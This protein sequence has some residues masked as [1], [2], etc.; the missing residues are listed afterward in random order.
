V[1]AGRSG[2]LGVRPGRASAA[3][4]A[5]GL[6]ALLAAAAAAWWWTSGATERFYT[7]GSGLRAGP[8]DAP[9]RDVLWRTPEALDGLNSNAQE[10]A[11]SLSA[12]GSRLYFTRTGADGA[13][14]LWVARRERGSDAWAEPTPVRSVNTVDNEIGARESP[15]GE[16]LYFA[17]DRP[18]GAG[19]FDL[20][21][22]PRV[23]GPT[24][25]GWGRAEPVPGVNTRDNELS[26][27]PGPDG[28][29]LFASDRPVEIERTDEPNEPAADDADETGTGLGYELYERSAQGAIAR[30]ADLGSPAD[31]TSPAL[32][33]GG[34][35]LYFASDRER[36]AGGLD[37]YRARR[38]T[39]DEGVTLGAVE[40][41]PDLNT[42]GDE[43]DPWVSLEG[44]ALHFSSTAPAASDGAHPTGRHLFRSVTR[45]VYLAERSRF[46][47]WGWL[48]QVLP[49]LPWILA[50]LAAVLLLALLRRAATHTSWERG[51]ATVGL[52]ARCVLAS[53]LVHAGLIAMM[54]VW[55]VEPPGSEPASG[56]D[57]ARIALATSGPG[58][59][60]RRQLRAPTADMAAAPSDTRRAGSPADGPRMSAPADER[61]AFSPPSDP[62]PSARSVSSPTSPRRTIADATPPDASDRIDARAGDLPAAPLAGEPLRADASLPREA[63]PVRTGERSVP[64]AGARPVASSARAPAPANT[65]LVGDVPAHEP[66]RDPI[67]AS[68]ERPERP[69]AIARSARDAVPENDAAGT[70]PAPLE[71]ARGM[72][73]AATEQAAIALPDTSR[74]S[75][76]RTESEIAGAIPRTSADS[77]AA[78]PA[79][80]VAAKAADASVLALPS[81]TTADEL[82][83]AAARTTREALP[84]IG[85]ASEPDASRAAL[86]I[87]GPAL[88]SP[89]VALPGSDQRSTATAEAVGTVAAEPLASSDD[90]VP[91]LGVTI[92]TATNPLR[93]EIDPAPLAERPMSTPRTDA[94]VRAPE[95]AQL[96]LAEGPSGPLGDPAGGFALPEFVEPVESA[97]RLTGRVLDEKTG[98][99]LA[100]AGVRIDLPGRED[101]IAASDGSGLFALTAR[102]LPDTIA[103]TAAR[104]GYVPGALSMTEREIEA[105]ADIEIRLAPV[106]LFDVAL[107]PD[108][109][110]HHLGDDNFDGR[111]NSQ[112]QRES[113]GYAVEIGFELADAQLDGAIGGAELTLLV[114]GSQRDNRVELNGRPV[115][116]L[117]ESP[118]DGSFGRRTLRV[119]TQ[120]LRDGENTLRVRSGRASGSDHDDFEFVNPRLILTPAGGFAGDGDA[121][122]LLRG[123]VVDVRTGAPIEGARV[124]L[125][126]RERDALRAITGP[127]GRFGIG[128]GSLPERLALTATAEGYQPGAATM[129]RACGRMTGC[130]CVN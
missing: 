130:A 119:P 92:T 60:V 26:P 122:L 62:L 44:F 104:D 125:A 57:R 75:A 51:I 76:V 108:P 90:L 41:L 113:E 52:L 28:M 29:L 49:L 106:D 80:G 93:P 115:G 87:D 116:V 100:G 96:A 72:G 36:G 95:E 50:A 14:G 47:G 88:E 18:G 40:P 9:L 21:R 27:T 124:T 19:G 34:D 31:E 13:S 10:R 1:R 127:R 15:D 129:S 69:V 102:D 54:S 82:P 91:A 17:S 79:L 33:P 98:E 11:P 85:L 23:G 112:F 64:D 59:T 84:D 37:L 45:E 70:A 53:L 121:D 25:T 61:Q 126:R 107:E 22:A 3:G 65:A 105:G 67:A 8:E 32:S 109:R 111:I 63:A 5:L 4:A 77:D 56:N 55:A 58:A 97:L 120:L 71:P 99:P 7:D 73:I 123:E 68:A 94:G 42:A 89:G 35:F 118:G 46:A 101:L 78:M 20:W 83:N 2:H 24:G 66:L 12:D 103:V 128:A 6:A 16:W 117:G 30:L 114:K 86:G 48:A 43:T 110:V 39:A 81:G 74:P 38:V